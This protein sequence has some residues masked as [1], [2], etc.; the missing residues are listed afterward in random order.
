MADGDS[1]QA[2]R[3]GQVAGEAEP[4]V[5]E[6]VE[7]VGGLAHELRNP[8]STVAINLKLLAETLEDA[9]VPSDDMRR[10]ALIKVDLLRREC[11]RL[12]TLFNEFLTL[13][14]PFEPRLS[15]VKPFELIERL[16]SFVEPTARSH[17]VT[18]DYSECDPTLELRLD[19]DL[20]SQSLLNLTIN[21]ID[22]MPEGGTLRL[23]C[24]VDGS[25]VRLEVHDTGMGIPG[26]AVGEVFRPFYSTKGG[27]TGLGLSITRR[28]VEA[29]GGTIRVDSV[30][31]RGSSFIITIPRERVS[32][33]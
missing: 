3:C 32:I 22:A 15:R 13:T 20:I 14:K 8:L 19:S 1:S 27:G 12:K 23:V 11:E 7:L 30:P 10:R 33:E 5:G 4:S 24:R 9:S 29:H 6:L 26:A 2:K 17:G 31:G 25:D 28:I 21:A 18:L 16:S